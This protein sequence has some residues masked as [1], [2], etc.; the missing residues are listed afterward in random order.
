MQ[1]PLLPGS[2]LRLVLL[3][4]LIRRAGRKTSTAMP[5]QAKQQFIQQIADEVVENNF[6]RFREMAFDL[7]KSFSCRVGSNNRSLNFSM[8][9][10]DDGDTY[11]NIEIENLHRNRD[12]TY[13]N[14][15][16]AV[17]KAIGHAGNLLSHIREACREPRYDF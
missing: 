9:I 11:F 4:T 6:V 16:S 3:P 8:D 17:A 13:P 10:Y 1:A 2:T 15:S 5:I 14:V 7:G 12:H